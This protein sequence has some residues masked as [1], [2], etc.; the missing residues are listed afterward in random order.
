MAAE[1]GKGRKTMSTALLESEEMTE[2]TAA[3]AALLS[4][5]PAAAGQEAAWSTFTSIPAPVRTDETWRFANVKDLDLASYTQPLPLDESTREDLLAR[6]KG[7]SE[8]SGRMIFGND[9]LLSRE[10][11]S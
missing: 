1:T 3:P 10:V 6:S 4:A 7:L 9:Q 2:T 5:G 8:V 11:L